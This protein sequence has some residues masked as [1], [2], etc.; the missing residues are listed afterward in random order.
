MRIEGS[1]SAPRL[2]A[3]ALEG[4]ADVQ[5]LVTPLERPDVPVGVGVPRES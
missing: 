1:E 2:T 4:A 5:R 3:D